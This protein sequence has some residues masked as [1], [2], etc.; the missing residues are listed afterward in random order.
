MNT[1]LLHIKRL[2]ITILLSTT[3]CVSAQTD[4]NISYREEPVII[5][6]DSIRQFICEIQNKSNNNIWILFESDSTLTNKEIIYH[7]FKKRVPSG[8]S[9]YQW[10]VDGN[11]NWNNF[12][13]D[14][15]STFFKI[16]PPNE[17]FNIISSHNFSGNLIPCLR[18]ITTEEIISY[19]HALANLSPTIYPSYQLNVL[20]ID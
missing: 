7:R 12:V 8:M 9:M 16:L 19:F 10:M 2:I 18:I 6:G 13:P 11:V 20:L 15:N 17:I 3:F 5:E 4:Y 1:P 14:L